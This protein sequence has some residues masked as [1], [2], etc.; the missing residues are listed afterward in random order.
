VTES[1]EERWEDTNLIVIK[2]GKREWLAEVRTS[3]H[4]CRIRAMFLVELLHQLGHMLLAI[5]DEYHNVE[6]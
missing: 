2:K 6:G 3:R 4:E 1:K 5:T